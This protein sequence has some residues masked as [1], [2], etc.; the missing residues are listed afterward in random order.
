MG[1]IGPGNMLLPH[2]GA[3]I[4]PV[5]LIPTRNSIITCLA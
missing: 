5:N 3:G 1:Q 2:A 4:S